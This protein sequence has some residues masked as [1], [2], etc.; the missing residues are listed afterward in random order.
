M[1]GTATQNIR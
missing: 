1:T